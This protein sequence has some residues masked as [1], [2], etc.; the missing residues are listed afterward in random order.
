MF[1]LFLLLLVTVN[2]NAQIIWSSAS[3]YAWLT[4]S[5]W[6]GGIAPSATQ[7]AQFNSNPTSA[8]TGIGINMDTASGALAGGAIS[9]SN[10]RTN[11][12][13]IGNSSPTTSGVLSLSGAT[14]NSTANVILSNLATNTSRLTIQ[15][16]Q[17]T[18]ASSM[19]IS[20]G[21]GSKNIVTG[22]G[23]ATAL[24][25]TINLTTSISGSATLNFLGNGTWNATISTGNNGGLLKLGAANTFTGG[26]NIGMSDGSLCGILELDTTNALNNIAGNNLTINSNSQLYLAATNNST[27]SANNIILHLNGNGNNY[28]STGKG[29]LVNLSGNNYTWDGAINLAS[30]AGITVLGSATTSVTCSGNL[31]GAG[32]LIKEGIGNLVL[33]GNANSW[34]G[35]TQINNGKI[36]VNEGSGISTGALLLAQI[37]NNPSLV[38]NTIVQS[39]TSLSSSFSGTNNSNTI[40]LNGTRLIINQSINTIYGGSTATQLSTITG[41]G[42]VLKI[43]IGRL[44]L[45]SP[46][47]TFSGGLNITAGEVR[48]NP[49][50]GTS[51]TNASPDTLNGGT[52]STNGISRPFTFTFG[53]LAITDNSTIDLGTDTAHSLKFANSNA[54]LWTTGKTLTIINWKGLWNGTS[55]T[56]GKLYI[57]TNTSGATATQLSQIKFIDGLGNT[58]NAA[59]LATGEI[60]PAAPAIVTNVATYGPY[61]NNIDNI[62]N[63]AYTYTGPITG[64][65]LVQL[66]SPTGIFTNDFVTGII[67]SGS[68]SPIAATIPTGTLAGTAYKIRVIN[69]SP[70]NTFGSNNG[71]AII[72]N[73]VPVLPAITGSPIVPLGGTVTWSNAIT[74]GTWSSNNTSI[75]SV[76]T[77]TGTITGTNAGTTTITYT[78][79]NFCGFTGYTTDTITVV[80][81]PTIT[82]VTPN[83][84]NQGASV[85]INGN[86]F[87]TTPANNSVYFGAVKATIV[88]A[89]STAISVTV[90]ANASFAPISVTDITTGLSGNAQYPF[91]PTYDN[92]GLIN[93]SANFKSVINFTTG[94]TP[95]GVS[96]ADLDGDGKSD[97]VV[98]NSGPNNIYVYH[99][100]STSGILNASS[101]EAPI[102]Y[103][104]AFGPHYVKIADLDGDGKPE[105]IVTNT[106]TSA[107]KIS[108][109]KN[110]STPGFISFAA[111]VDITASIAPIDIAIADFD[112]DGKPD[113]AAIVQNSNKVSIFRNTS[114]HGIISATSFTYTTQ[115]TTGSYPFRIFAGD[116]DGDNKPDIALTNYLSNN[117]SIYHNSATIAN[118]NGTSFAT[119]TTITAGISP[120][121]IAGGDIDGDGKPDLI[122]TNSGDNT[123]SIFRNNN[124]TSGIISFAAGNAYP[125]A[126][127]P[128]DIAIADA[129]GDGKNDIAIG[130]YSSSNVSVYLNTAIA[131]TIDASSVA[132]AKSFATG[133]NPAGIA[134][135][136]IDSDGKA[137]IAVVSGSTSSVGIL[138]NYPLPRIGNIIG[139]NS[140]CTGTSTTLTNAVTGGTWIS[141]QPTIATISNTGI[142]HAI[143]PGIDTILYYTVAQGDTNSASFIINVELFHTV[144]AITA[145]TTTI[146]TGALASLADTVG[147][148]V[149]ISQN[150]SIASVDTSGFV[151]GNTAGTTTISYSITN[152]CG[153]SF[154][155]INITVNAAA[156]YVI[157]NI[158]GPSALCTGT[159]ATLSDTSAGGSWISSNIAIATISTAGVVT[160]LAYGNA[161]ITYSLTTSCGSYQAI[162]PIIVD[163]ILDATTIN[164][165]NNVCPGATITLTNAVGT[166]GIWSSNNSNAS[167]T[168]TGIVT[169]N[170][171]GMDTI[172]YT[173]S[174]T[175]GSSTGFKEITIN[176]LPDAGI[177]SGLATTC[178]GDTVL[179]TSSLSGGVWTL[180]NTNASTLTNGK[181][182]GIT[183]GTDTVEY[184]MSNICGMDTATKTLTILPL[185]IAGII[186]GL[187]VICPG[188]SITL[189]DTT[190]GAI[191]SSIS[192]NVSVADSIVT[193]INPG[194]D[195]VKVT[196][197]NTCG[198]AVTY[199][200]ITINTIT[201]V[202]TI[203]GLSSVCTGASITL[204]NTT[205]S[206][207][208]SKTNAKANISI[209]GVVTG[210]SAGIDT[211]KY[212]PRGTCP[213]VATK[214]ITVIATPSAGTIISAASVCV[215]DTIVLHDTVT[216]GVWSNTNRNSVLTDT[217][218]TGIG[219]GVDTVKYTITSQCGFTSV[220]KKITINPLPYADEI[221]GPNS[222]YVGDAITLKDSTAGGV[223][224]VVGTNAIIS[225][226]GRVGGLKQGVDT[227]KYTYTNVCGS[228][229]AKLPITIL[230]SSNPGSIANIELYPNPNTGTFSVK[231]SSLINE[232]VNVVISNSAYQVINV[233]SVNTNVTTGINVDLA[234][235]LYFLS[236]VTEKGWYTVKFIIVK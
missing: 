15:N 181:I 57:G 134:W 52:M 156:S 224:G 96:M 163:S 182:K 154:D 202:D 207:S 226:T 210:V 233:L 214:P 63:V 58:F 23:T 185:P 162:M 20:V 198:T 131:G 8:T 173:I 25:N 47:N 2:I 21:S 11:A 82:S 60:V 122:V 50:S 79:T 71:S 155:T 126:S 164:G 140:I 179:F 151:T 9:V 145:T 142:V 146:C 123:F 170:T 16:T 159:S 153:T 234:D 34:T 49:T 22:N 97:M 37:L 26:M 99:N 100:I 3:G 111:K 172:Q 183:A 41:S 40:T 51:V 116:L 136:D 87:N 205:D 165:S 208:W 56:K 147:G 13:V 120:T 216:G 168:S 103:P 195:S 174:N 141:K 92:T 161:I 209:T 203:A 190:T 83:T 93:D 42:S 114:T 128:E 229:I 117:I 191:W 137:D 171:A 27:Y 6:T 86:N 125:T 124:T 46:A 223:W 139:D 201:P 215:G 109:F 19:E 189:R 235:G 176:P 54:I 18:G 59:I 157:G 186:S 33:S 110:Q 77:T 65:F 138:K 76:N 213:M 194:T 98:V 204:T 53:T 115:Y 55:G 102:S 178:P 167:V 175:C 68:S 36:T 69:A 119:I 133:A 75:A 192:G 211:I 144:A 5:N 7:I 166:G 113:I 24:G 158:A 148:G 74:G 221:T 200:K 44:T 135:T 4:G 101:Y 230:S 29:A 28:T 177:V 66:S 85:I 62:L 225:A 222:L 149:W 227:I 94:A 127:V 12:L 112:G 160:G 80:P 39:I 228:Y 197:T 32:Q 64:T 31:T 73:G 193:G 17:G 78:Y 188:A 236:T 180:T 45:T 129:N 43:G 105:I 67:G 150:T 212:T 232:N 91:I 70:V 220:T 10:T 1:L 184:I 107:N 199:K 218:L 14:I 89:S 130:N 35:G 169:G 81:I 95:I 90:P 187:S 106:S 196:V 84:G 38:L 48:Y 143:T 219:A 72:V 61:C 121:A 104:T 118:I 217:L 152:S 206:G 30:D 108:I 88:T 231:L 132:P